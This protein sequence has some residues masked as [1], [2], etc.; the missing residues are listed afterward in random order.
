MASDQ[1]WPKK[2]PQTSPGKYWAYGKSP[3]SKAHEKALGPAPFVP[4]VP[5]W[6]AGSCPHREGRPLERAL[7]KSH[8][9]FVSQGAGLI[10]QSDSSK[11]DPLHRVLHTGHGHHLCSGLRLQNIKK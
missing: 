9:N 5:R 1:V 11:T 3:A 2:T 10:C 4:S 8:E 7:E 6:E